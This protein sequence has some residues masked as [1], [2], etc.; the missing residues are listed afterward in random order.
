MGLGRGSLQG[1]AGLL[2]CGVFQ[3]VPEAVALAVHLQDVDA[4]SQAV[5]QRAGRP[6][7]AEHHSIGNP[8]VGNA[9]LE[10]ALIALNMGEPEQ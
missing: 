10:S 9:G 8:T 7:R 4:A 3:A 6:L 5:Q 1:S 2:V